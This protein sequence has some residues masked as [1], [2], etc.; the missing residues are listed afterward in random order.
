MDGIRTQLLFHTLAID[1][2]DHLGFCFVDHQV[3]WCGRRLVDV[4]VAIGRIPSVDPP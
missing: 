2:P 1:L 4:G 3:L